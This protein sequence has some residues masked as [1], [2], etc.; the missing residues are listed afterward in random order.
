MPNDNHPRQ[1]EIRMFIS[2]TFRDMH[3]ER[4]ELVKQ[5]FPQLRRLCESRGVTWGEVDLRWGVPDEAKAEGKVLPLCLAEIARCRPYFIGLL[6]ERYGWVPEEIPEELLEAQPW[7]NEH[8]K[9]S[10]T[11]LEILHGVLRN[12]EM[13]GHAFFY[14]R[15]PAFADRH[16]GFTEEDF[17]RR[18]R[19][20]ALKDN[21][22][23][24]RFPVA[25]N[26]ATPKQLGEWVLRD[27]TAVIEK[28]YPESSIPDPLDRAAADHEAYAAS[29]RRVYIGRPQ[30]FE[31][32][33]AHASGEGP[34]LVVVGESGGGKS[35][36]LANWTH[37][38]SEEHPETQ[39]IV[40]FIGAAPDS[41]DWMAML[42][43]LLGEFKRHFGIQ[44]EIPD[45]PDALRMA[46]ANAL[47]MVAARGR[48]VLALDALN[49]IEDRD[50]AL[51]LVWLPPVIPANVRLILS[52]LAG[53]P[54]E[55]L[56]KRAWPV[57]T[58]EPLEPAERETLI[59]D[60]LKQ[61]AK[62]LSLPHRKRIAAAP[63]SANGLYLTTVLNELRLFGS[64]EELDRRIGWYLEAADPLELYGKVIQRWERDYEE[65]GPQSE[66]IV[67]ESLSRLWAA[68]RGL[69]ETE[70]LE[71]LGT[72][73]SPLPRAVW[74]PLFLAASDALVNRGGLLTFAH[75]FLREAVRE[76]YLP[77]LDL[78]QR[79]HGTLA[80]YFRS[81]PPGPRQ[82]DELPWQ[83][84]EAHAWEPLK[85]ILTEQ[86]FFDAWWEA[87]EF[88]LKEYWVELAAGSV[89]LDTVSASLRIAKTSGRLSTLERVISLLWDTGHRETAIELRKVALSDARNAGNRE[90]LFSYLNNLAIMLRDVGKPSEAMTLH[91]EAE[92]VARELGNKGAWACS[93][94]NQAVILRDQGDLNT[95][96]LL[97]N[98][99]AETWKE[100]GS[101][102][103]MS[104]NLGNRALILRDLGNPA[105]GLK[106]IEEQERLCRANGDYDELLAVL[107]NRGAFLNNFGRYEE[108]LALWGAQ[109][110]MARRLGD[111]RV[112]SVALG[113][114]ASDLTRRGDWQGALP[115]FQQQETI[116]RALGDPA[117]LATCLGN[118]AV[119]YSKQRQLDQATERLE[120]QERISREL[121][122]KR[123]LAICLCTK[124]GVL[125]TRGLP[126]AALAVLEDAE[127]VFR[128]LGD[129]AQLAQCL[130]NQGQVLHG[131]EDLQRAINLH[132]EEEAIYRELN[133]SHGA[134]NAIHGQARILMKQNKP[135]EALALLRLEESIRRDLREQL[136]LADCLREQAFVLYEGGENQQSLILL[137]EQD[138]LC[139]ALSDKDGL[140]RSLTLHVLI[141]HRL[142]EFQEAMVLL[143][144]H[145]QLCRDLDNPEWTTTSLEL[146]GLTLG[147][148]RQKEAGVS[149]GSA[150]VAHP[151]ANADEAA[152]RNMEYRAK[153]ARWRALP[154]WKR[155]TTPRPPMPPGVIA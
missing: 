78:Q 151:G 155:F 61:F 148:M 72:E 85:R 75:D 104:K 18:E 50:G 15:D 108:A 27:L 10:V 47:H 71:S 86:T 96:L 137:R 38:R 116:L 34:P 92:L 95:S 136:K 133:D 16:T 121:G 97:L 65:R 81:Q 63:Q 152:R 13:S 20:A 146:R 139:R 22:R 143:K 120:E 110:E 58:V 118:Q 135:S 103:E 153:L 43:R 129:K 141:L 54:L 99:S 64:H 19:L 4:E 12:P 44:I 56:R 46:F 80:D 106:L 90:N 11:A 138:R 31:R 82:V 100:L 125:F 25:E 37:P 144:E 93:L 30:Y 130:G 48:V 117:L 53:R 91:K 88:Q 107:G 14:F 67:G 111:R 39:V 35:A 66:D 28:L 114:R 150:S 109:E 21:V 45:Q 140:R 73:G 87:D 149:I 131:M 33:D 2:S 68:R 55:D 23:K 123:E 76:A 145:E 154:W 36:L 83:L 102:N 70:L 105:A 89:L 147:L 60:Y 122:S 69:S 59:V 132:L 126:D 24:S 101:T 77:T 40:H 3:E 113:N 62:Q 41:A 6:G 1:R 142:G 32:L 51:D 42:R 5:I 79:A 57:L 128:D 17:A 124:G 112:L 49:Q 119:I 127:K 26:F 98:Q 134:A 8:R 9:E 84:H 115:L 7:L 52:T 94:D 29:R 74:S